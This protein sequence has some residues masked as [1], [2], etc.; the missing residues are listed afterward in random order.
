MYI[1]FWKYANRQGGKTV[2]NMGRKDQE[3]SWGR[4]DLNNRCIFDQSGFVAFLA[5]KVVHQHQETETHNEEDAHDERIGHGLREPVVFVLFV[6]NGADLLDRDKALRV[7]I[8]S[9]QGMNCCE[10]EVILVGVLNATTE[11]RTAEFV[12]AVVPEH[13][14]RRSG[15]VNL[16]AAVVHIHK[17]FLEFY[18]LWNVLGKIVRF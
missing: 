11:L 13:R 14:T 3:E 9:K 17:G 8:H 4:L 16:R 18:L 7:L 15:R 10:I 1:V 6:G 12:Q 2:H 5:V